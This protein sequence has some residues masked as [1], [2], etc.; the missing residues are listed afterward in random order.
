MVGSYTKVWVPLDALFTASGF[1][2]RMTATGSRV[3]PTA[4]VRMGTG[5][6]DEVDPRDVCVKLHYK[7]PH[8]T[9]T[10]SVLPYNDHVQFSIGDAE[11]FY[12]DYIPSLPSMTAQ[13]LMDMA[14]DALKGALA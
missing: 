9:L 13:D 8:F 12:C 1:V 3:I 14:T 7:L 5:H 2:D 6:T 11:P 10:V 4:K